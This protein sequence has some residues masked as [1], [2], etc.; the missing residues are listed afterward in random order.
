MPSDETP[1]RWANGESFTYARSVVNARPGPR[2][3]GPASSPKMTSGEMEG[4]TGD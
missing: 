4:V 1:D 3:V 2:P